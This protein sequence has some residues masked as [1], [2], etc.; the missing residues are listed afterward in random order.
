[1]LLGE[2]WM[3]PDI[4]STFHSQRDTNPP[5]RG[6]RTNKF[7]ANPQ[8][9]FAPACHM[10]GHFYSAT[11]AQSQPKEQRSLGTPCERGGQHAPWEITARDAGTVTGEPS[12]V[13]NTREA[14]L[15][16]CEMPALSE[17]SILW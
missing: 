7:Y 16:Q 5:I 17:A 2:S 8:S 4:K 3:L 9:R 10:N 12:R 15:F 14:E 11:K 1:M 13:V 6:K